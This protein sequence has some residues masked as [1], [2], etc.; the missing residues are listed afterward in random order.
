[1]GIS[2]N[3]GLMVG[4]PYKEM[5]ELF[6]KAGRDGLD[7]LIHDGELDVGSIYYDSDRKDNI[8]GKWLITTSNSIEISPELEDAGLKIC[9]ALVKDYPNVEF[10]LYLTLSIT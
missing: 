2:K 8:V 10:K 9:E 6:T 7:D 4:L 5:Q 1:M 3:C